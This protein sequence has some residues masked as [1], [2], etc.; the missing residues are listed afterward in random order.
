MA[1]VAIIFDRPD[2]QH[3]RPAHQ[4]AHYNYLKEN[5]DLILLRGGFP[6]ESGVGFI[7]GMLV[8]DVSSREAAQAFVANDPFAQAGMQ[9]EVTIVH[10]T[11]AHC[12]AIECWR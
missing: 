10:F 5:Q 9:G 3:L 7:G 12:A 11:P 4:E 1:Y 8:L 6:N 2:R